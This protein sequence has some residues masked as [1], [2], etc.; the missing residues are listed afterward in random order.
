MDNDSHNGTHLT[1]GEFLTEITAR[2]SVKDGKHYRVHTEHHMIP[3]K[4]ACTLLPGCVCRAVGTLIAS[5]NKLDP[6]TAHQVVISLYNTYREERDAASNSETPVN[7]LDDLAFVGFETR[8]LDEDDY[9]HLIP[10]EIYAP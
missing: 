8:L 10:M 4:T 6:P 5:L 9:I 3:T 2:A 1:I 7:S